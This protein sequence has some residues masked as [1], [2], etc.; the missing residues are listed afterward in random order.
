M[1]TYGSGTYG[2]GTYGDPGGEVPGPEPIIGRVA[3]A[4]EYPPDKLAWR[5]DPPKGAPSRW[6]ADEPLAENVCEDIQ[7]S[8]EMPGGEKEATCNLA[9]NPRTP[10][11]DLAQY[12]NV[13]VYGP[14]GEVVWEGRL[15][16]SPESDGDR[17]AI[18]PAAVGWKQALEDDNSVIGPGYI[19][20]DLGKWGEPST[21]R[22][23]ELD[24]ANRELAA[25]VSAGWQ[26]DGSE[27]PALNIDFT[28]VETAAGKWMRGE[29]WYDGGGIPLGALLYEFKVLA[30]PEGNSAWFDGPTLHSADTDVAGFD[31]VID[32]NATSTSGMQE[33]AA[34]TDNRRY[35]VVCSEFIGE[36]GTRMGDIHSWRHLKV[37]SRL[38]QQHLALQGTWPNVGYTAS[39]MLRHAIPTYTCLRADAEDVEDT[40]Y[41]IEQAWF[42]EPGSILEVVQELTKYELLDWFVR[43][44]RFFLKRPGTYGRRWQAYAGPSGLEEQGED[45]SRS[46]KEITVR[47][48]DVTGRTFT[49]GPPGSGA[50]VEDARLEITDPDHPAVR[51]AE[52]YGPNFN[53]KDLLD[54]GGISTPTRAR[55]AGERWLREANL[56]S[57]S[58]SCSLTGYV[59]DDKGAFWPVSA[60][61]A[62]DMIRFPDAGD[63]SY[64]KVVSRSYSHSNRTASLS[65]DAP[66]QGIT[67]LLER[68]QAS[69]K[70]LQIS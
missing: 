65:L 2:S 62:G 59:M 54:L 47:G 48:Q 66:A 15:D 26:G 50:T 39:Q 11:P 64:R 5:I 68:M 44:K 58:G 67:A 57:R 32:H 36:G 17:M 3:V 42:S 10:W 22:R 38:A 29:S 49:V 8:E 27:P 41:I 19:D 23:L 9:R 6:A 21:Q 69:I 63:T 52:A 70:R 55:E 40:N 16:K 46:W 31:G 60:V 12:S 7:L 14:G 45:G 24:T 43:G 4:H 30:G 53:R 25:A 35:A 28:S 1:S 18:K 56:L 13:T 51:A 37:I 33:R 34:T 61:R 20:S